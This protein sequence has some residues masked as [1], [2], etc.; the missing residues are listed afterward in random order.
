MPALLD[1]G[2][3]VLLFPAIPLPA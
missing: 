2:A 1:D 3:R